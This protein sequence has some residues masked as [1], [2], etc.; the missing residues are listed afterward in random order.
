M[1]RRIAQM[2]V[3]SDESEEEIEDGDENQVFISN[4][5]TSKGVRA[6]NIL[7]ISRDDVRAFLQRYNAA[8]GSIEPVDA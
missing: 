8:G 1:Y 3:R 2:Q 6:D 7:R 5:K 4:N